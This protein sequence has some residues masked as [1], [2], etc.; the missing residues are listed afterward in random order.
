MPSFTCKHKINNHTH[1]VQFRGYYPFALPLTKVTEMLGGSVDLR[2]STIR[3]WAA[4]G[5]TFGWQVQTG[6]ALARMVEDEAKVVFL[7]DQ[8]LI[9]HPG[10]PVTVQVRERGDEG[11]RKRQCHFAGKYT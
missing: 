1:P 3:V 5:D 6:W 10:M 8:P 9:F 4:A 11:D 7:G 2:G